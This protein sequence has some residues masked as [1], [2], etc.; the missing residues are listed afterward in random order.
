VFAA[1][2]SGF[3]VGEN[4]LP[5]LNLPLREFCF[6]FNSAKYCFKMSLI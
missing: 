4:V 6:V 2:G 3:F 5:P 1:C